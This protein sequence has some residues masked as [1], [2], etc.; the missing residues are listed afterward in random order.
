M[1]SVVTIVVISVVVGVALLIGLYFLWR[2]YY[3]SKKQLARRWLDAAEA[4]KNRK[5]CDLPAK[6][7]IEDA[8]RNKIQGDAECEKNPSPGCMENARTRY[9]EELKPCNEPQMQTNQC[10]QDLIADCGSKVV[11][12]MKDS[13]IK[14]QFDVMKEAR[15]AS[16][17]L[18]LC[19]NMARLS[20]AF[21]ES[22]EIRRSAAATQKYGATTTK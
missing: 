17:T 12:P 9:R 15:P 20:A 14:E 19:Q 18:N 11:D 7:C 22:E 5:E 3:G 10:M 6:K 8:K 16:E 1:V 2:W 4:A 13:G 21:S